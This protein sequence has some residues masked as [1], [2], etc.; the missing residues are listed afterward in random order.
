LCSSTQDQDL[1][2]LAARQYFTEYGSEIS[3]E[4]LEGVLP[5]YIPA[6]RRQQPESNKMWRRL[7]TK[8]HQRLFGSRKG[9]ESTID[10]VKLD[11]VQYGKKTWAMSFSR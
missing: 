4:G 10:E 8:A 11:V 3:E 7:V 5:S 6:D 2:V 9:K 1:A